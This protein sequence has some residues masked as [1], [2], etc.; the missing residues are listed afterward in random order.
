MKYPIFLVHGMGIRD[1]RGRGYWGRIPAALEANGFK[2]AL[3]GQDCDGSIENNAK[4]IAVRLDEVLKEYNASKVNIIAHS[5]GGLESRYLASTL[6]YDDKIASI[7]T[8]STPHHGSNTV[9]FLMKVPDRIIKFA[10]KIAD[11][12]FG[13]I[14]D[15]DPQTY[16]AICVFRTED[17]ALFNEQTPDSDKVFYQSYG[18]QMKSSRSDMLMWLT[19]SVVRHFD[20]DND[21]LLSPDS[22]RWTNFKPVV[23]GAKTRGISHCDEVDVRRKPVMLN[24]ENGIVDITDLYVNIAKEIEEKGF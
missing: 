12:C 16:E 24:T 1:D 22:A 20:G 19:H 15:K 2:V 11:F 21:G 17:A 4:Q 3:S 9:D 13:K 6:G 10:C 5:K 7:T 23:T 8:I 14:G 18:F